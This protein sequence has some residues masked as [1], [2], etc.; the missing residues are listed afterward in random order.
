MAASPRVSRTRTTRRLTWIL[1]V[2]AASTIAA[3]WLLTPRDPKP[4][5]VLAPPGTSHVTIALSDLY[6]PFLSPGENADLRSRLPDSVEIVA[7]YTRTTTTYSLLS[8][9]YGLGCLPDPQWNQ[10]TDEEVRR[11]TATVTPRRGLDTL[12][13][14]G[15]D[16]PHRIDDGFSIA[17]FAVVLSPGALPRQPGYQAL[18]SRSGEAHAKPLGDNGPLLDY[19]VRFDAQDTGHDAGAGSRNVQ[20]C[21]NTILPIALPGVSVPIVTTLTTSTPSMSLTGSTRCPMPDALAN[22]IPGYDVTPGI[23]VPAVPGRLPPS[24]IAAAQ[25]A[26]DL[27]HH[28]GATLLSGPFTPTPAM[29]RWYHRN[30]EGPDAYLI[31][32]GPYRQLEV[33]MRFDNAHPVNGLLPIRTERWTFFDDALVGYTADINYFVDTQKGIV[34]FN[35]HWDQYFHDGKTVFTQTTSRPCDDAVSCGNDVAGNPEAQAVSGA[36]RAA[37]R[38][39][40]AEIRDWMTRPYD[41]LQAEAHAYLQFRGVLKPVA[42]R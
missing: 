36:V 16:L 9:S 1:G 35:T 40:L 10:H 31:E 30:D 4:R 17:S 18:V 42:D 15:F 12:R 33:R 5:D 34:I 37:G 20:D 24:R 27:D 39:A 11:L 19:S 23:N 29:V 26:L 6:M 8:C 13:T 14:I 28:D 25:V 7:H 41:A 38:D 21:L 3:W 22:A 2:A 32:F